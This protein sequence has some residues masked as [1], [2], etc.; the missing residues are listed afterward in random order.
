MTCGPKASCLA[1]LL[2][3]CSSSGADPALDAQVDA[4]SP[5]ARLALDAAVFDAGE[6]DARADAS[7][8]ASVEGAQDAALE[9]GEPFVCDVQLP[10]SC[11]APAPTYADVAPIIA[12]RC[13]V[14]H[15]QV[16]TGNWP[17]DTY[18]H[19]ASWRE[20]IR[21]ELVNCTMPPRDSGLSIPD[22]ERMT[23][24]TWIRC[25]LPR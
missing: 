7:A 24:L 3:A 17:L 6:H 8:D 21:T 20:E 1:L 19:V 9:A 12:Q 11:P 15:G 18:S 22:E 4:E 13:A 5:D 16:Q 2:V 23:I 25:D 14:C 10:T